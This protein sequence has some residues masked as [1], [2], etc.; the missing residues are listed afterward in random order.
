MWHIFS[1]GCYT[2]SKHNKC[3]GTY[4]LEDATGLMGEFPQYVSV[5]NSVH[6]VTESYGGYYGPIFS[7]YIQTQNA[8]IANKTAGFDQAKTIN[9]KSLIIGDG[10]Y[11]SQTQYEAYYNFTVNP[12]NTYD[13]SPCNATLQTQLFN[14]LYAKG[15]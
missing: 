8:L 9:L 14:N 5:N 3:R 11:D 7:S 4:I 2:H 1:S 13:F 15:A 10:F 12:G 6:I